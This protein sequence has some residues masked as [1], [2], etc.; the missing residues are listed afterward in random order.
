MKTWLLVV[1]LSGWLAA[2]EMRK[3]EVVTNYP[4]ELSW[5]FPSQSLYTRCPVTPALRNQVEVPK[6][7]VRLRADSPGWLRN[8]SEERELNP[9]SEVET[10]TL[11]PSYRWERILPLTL[12]LVALVIWQLRKLQRQQFRQALQDQEPLIR[13]DGAIPNRVLNGY[14][15]TRVLGA[16][17]MGVVYLG[18]TKR[19]ERCAIKVPLPTFLSD[20]DFAPRFQRE[21]ETGLKLQHPRIARLL[22]FPT[23]SEPYLLMEYVEGVS[24]DRVTPGPLPQELPR[25]WQWCDQILEA[26]IFVHDSDV[27]HRDLKPANI[28]VLP[29]QSLKLMDFG[30]AH[31]PNRTR[32]T[33]TGSILGTPVFMAP[34]QVQGAPCDPSIDVY[35]LGVILYER[36]AGKLPF[37]TDCME[38]LSYK[39]GGPL[40]SLKNT[41]V[42]IPPGWSDFIDAL[43]APNP[44]NRPTAR[45]AREWLK[46]LPANVE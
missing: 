25:C 37:P 9:A 4:A 26:L 46:R 27:I 40:P 43:A 45:E 14:R 19:G 22:G 39:L 30:I 42:G 13:S 38:L 10:F 2:E 31:T 17:A 32:L 12:L 1:G 35:A 33:A 5:R 15:L 41:V 16:G 23:G 8:F 7:A 6:G 20:P 44:Q 29:D 28:M 34:E 36:L 21:L 24:L 11:L 3:L 18:E